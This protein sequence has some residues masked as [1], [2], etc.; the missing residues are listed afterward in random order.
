M[1]PGGLAPLLSRAQVPGLPDGITALR[2]VHE[3]R[4]KEIVVLAN[5]FFPPSLFYSQF[6][7]AEEDRGRKTEV[8]GKNNI[9][10]CL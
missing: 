3:H 5:S 1:G 9:L 7:Q 10:M 2:V 6:L 8:N 4:S